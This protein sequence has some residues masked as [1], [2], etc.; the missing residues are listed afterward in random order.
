MRL[1]HK[2][3]YK[4]AIKRVSID[5]KY[6]KFKSHKNTRTRLW[7]LI[8]NE[9]GE[10]TEIVTATGTKGKDDKIK[11]KVERRG[12]LKESP[13]LEESTTK[14]PPLPYRPFRFRPSKENEENEEN[15]ENG[16]N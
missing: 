1:Y 4:K 10:S 11:W 16:E 6:I 14:D 2:L 3:G 15:G 12:E 5:K 13:S 7:F 9:K 8:K